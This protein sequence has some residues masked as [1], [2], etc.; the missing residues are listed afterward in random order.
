MQVS[1][2]RDRDVTVTAIPVLLRGT[3]TAEKQWVKDGVVLGGWTEKTGPEADDCRVYDLPVRML[4]FNSLECLTNGK[5]LGRLKRE[6]GQRLPEQAFLKLRALLSLTDAL[7]SR[8]AELLRQYVQRQS[9]I[10]AKMWRSIAE[11]MHAQSPEE[12][13]PWSE[14]DRN[15]AFYTSKERVLKRLKR[16]YNVIGAEMT[17]LLRDVRFVLWWVDREGKFAPGLYCETLETALA[18]LMVSRIQ[19]SQALAVC[20]RKGCENTFIRMK[21]NQRFCSL[22]CG[23]AA[24]KAKERSKKRR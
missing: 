9:V 12:F 8:N 3:R 19:S 13:A 7:R 23:N 22:R 15:W 11:S 6:Y 16:P 18:A 20:Q 14:K 17:K 21:R 10:D 2:T 24:R 1:R 4:P 5:K